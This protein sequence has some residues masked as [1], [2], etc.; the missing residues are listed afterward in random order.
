[1][2]TITAAAPQPVGEVPASLVPE[3]EKRF[4][5][6]QDVTEVDDDGKPSSDDSSEFKQEGVKQV[7]AITTVWSKEL[8]IVMFVL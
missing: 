8:L 2:A 5:R 4:S 7:E 1:M 3:I 6:G